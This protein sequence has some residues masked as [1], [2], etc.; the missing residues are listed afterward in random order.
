MFEGYEVLANHKMLDYLGFIMISTWCFVQHIH[1]GQ[2]Y[3]KGSICTS[4]M[5]HERG[6]GVLIHDE[7]RLS[8]FNDIIMC[9]FVDF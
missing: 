6:G 4:D 9:L 5:G 1:L 2:H 3:I 8:R 7:A